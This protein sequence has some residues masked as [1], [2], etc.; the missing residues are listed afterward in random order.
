VQAAVLDVKLAHLPQWIAHR[1]S[2]AERYTAGLRGVGDLGLPD[3]PDDR[4]SDAWQNYVIRTGQRDALRGHLRDSGVETLV[5]WV[6]PVWQHQALGLGDQRLPV[7]EA[8]CREVISLPMS[9][10]LTEEHVDE[11]VGAIRSFF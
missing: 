5:H 10:E 6:R 9:A 4:F 3:W 8:I 11:T 2:M 7:T 1:R